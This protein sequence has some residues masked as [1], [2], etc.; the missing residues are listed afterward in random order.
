MENLILECIRRE[1][2]VT[3]GV[4]FNVLCEILSE[5]QFMILITQVRERLIQ[6][7]RDAEE[8]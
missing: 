3:D 8:G 7:R 4:Y 6:D 1:I 2:S 5:M